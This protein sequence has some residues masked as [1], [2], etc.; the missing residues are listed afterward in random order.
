MCGRFVITLTPD[1]ILMVFDT[2]TP[3]GYAPSYNVAPTNNIL[4]IPNTEDRAGMLAH[5]GMIAPWFKEPKANPKYPTINARSE[6][7]HEKKTYGG[8]LRSR[9]C[10]FPAT[11]FYEW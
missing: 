3:D 6:T 9:R 5:W 4:I 11:G 8:P 2:P 1:Q 10:L 7:A